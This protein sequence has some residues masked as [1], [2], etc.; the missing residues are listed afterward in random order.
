MVVATDTMKNFVLREA[1]AFDGAT[2]DGFATT[3]AATSSRPTR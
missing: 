2:L 3:S 1:L